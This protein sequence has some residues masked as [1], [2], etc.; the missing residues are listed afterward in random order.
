MDQLVAIEQR[1]R[2]LRIVLFVIILATLPFYCAGILLWGTAQR[3][4][5]AANLTGT[6]T[7]T[8]LPTIATQTPIPS[9]T[10]LS[11]SA[12]PFGG[13][14]LPTPGQY[15]PGTISTRVLSPTPF[16][17]PT[18]IFIPQPTQAPTL[19]PYPTQVLPTQPPPP[20]Q[21]NAP[22][23]PTQTD[24]PPAPT[25]EEPSPLP[26]PSDTPAPP[27]DQSGDATAQVGG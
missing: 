9:I 24:V 5:P 13:P 27:P 19:T 23:P 6:A 11:I 16:I 2:N 12:T 22:P 18:D 8:P 25:L 10:P 21:T 14:L 1:R 26:P 3:N 4:Q 20:T 15:N 7:F 17:L